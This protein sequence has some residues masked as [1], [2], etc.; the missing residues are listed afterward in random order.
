MHKGRWHDGRDVA[1]KVQYPGAG[2]ALMSDL[3]QLAR[4]A[5]TIGPLVPG[6]DIKP[7][8]AEMQARAG[9]ELDYQL[10]AEAQS[11]FADVVPRRPRRSSSPT[12]S[13]TA[14]PCW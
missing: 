10:E 7:L 12:W 2:D 5:R 14:T 4:L 8:I 6:V 3:R 13:R 1:V 11:R 9:E